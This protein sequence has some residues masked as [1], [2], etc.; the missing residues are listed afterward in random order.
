MKHPILTV[1]CAAA[2][3]LSGCSDRAQDLYETA[4]FEEKQH[5]RAHARQLY[6][7]IVKDY[8]ASQQAVK[9]RERLEQLADEVK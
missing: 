3:F 9:A 1:C 8:P 7:Q 6:E 4:Q 2:L 5:N